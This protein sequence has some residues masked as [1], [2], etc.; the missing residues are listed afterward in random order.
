VT[1]NDLSE[2]QQEKAIYLVHKFITAQ[3]VNVIARILSLE[4][5]PHPIEALTFSGC[6]P[7][8][9]LNTPVR[10]AFDKRK[11]TTQNTRKKHYI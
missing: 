1:P 11:F 4:Q 5:I 2:N 3:L 10:M 8:V 9:I 6:V 7:L